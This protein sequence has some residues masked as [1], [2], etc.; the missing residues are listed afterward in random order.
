MDEQDFVT[1]VLTNYLKYREQVDDS[2]NGFSIPALVK[3]LIRLDDPSI[4]N[5][6]F[7]SENME[8]VVKTGVETLCDHLVLTRAKMP[9]HYKSRV[10]TFPISEYFMHVG[11]DANETEHLEKLFSP[12]NPKL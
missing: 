11:Y 1:F 10:F 2:E 4:K 6:G 7:N 8:E 5:L 3:D 12:L 9:N